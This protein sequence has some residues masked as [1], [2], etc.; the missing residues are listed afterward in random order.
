MS[1]RADSSQTTWRFRC[2]ECGDGAH[3]N[4]CAQAIV[5]GRLLPDA[6]MGAYVEESDTDQTVL[7]FDSIE[8]EIHPSSRLEEFI[9][10]RWTYTAPCPGGPDDYDLKYHG[11]TTQ[12]PCEEG[13]LM[14]YGQRR[15][16]CSTC[17]GRGFV[18][19]PVEE[20]AHAA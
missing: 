5:T 19:L 2:S 13:W 7:F 8:C 15:R 17:A 11:E 10:G 4:A 16:R 3:L 20:P 18:E 14:K 6:E 9:D 1:E 12:Y